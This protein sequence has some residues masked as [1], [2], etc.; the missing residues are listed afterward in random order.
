MKVQVSSIQA[1]SP[2]VLDESSGAMGGDVV[3]LRNIVG[4]LNELLWATSGVHVPQVV[5]GVGG[6]KPSAVNH[7]PFGHDVVKRFDAVLGAP[8]DAVFPKELGA[9]D[10]CAQD[11]RPQLI[12]AMLK[13]AT[14]PK[15]VPF[16]KAVSSWVAFQF[17]Q[18]ILA[19]HIVGLPFCGLENGLD[20]PNAGVF[21]ST[22]QRQGPKPCLIP[23]LFFPVVIDGQTGSLVDGPDVGLSGL[24]QEPVIVASIHPQHLNFPRSIAIGVPCE[25]ALSVQVSGRV[26]AALVES[27]QD[28]AVVAVPHPEVHP[29]G[30]PN[31]VVLQL[32]A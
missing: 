5:C 23:R 16:V 6:K 17:T 27:G 7:I 15:G 14:H 12:S 21:S 18:E 19:Q 10:S 22:L 8:I 4:E 30:T 9:F 32:C 29:D 26:F 25:V 3:G 13:K 20:P 1:Q 31:M 2:G 28:I 11:P 24:G